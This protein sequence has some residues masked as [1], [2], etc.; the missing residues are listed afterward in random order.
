MLN[1]EHYVTLAGN[2]DKWDSEMREL[3]QPGTHCSLTELQESQSERG[4]IPAVLVESM[5][6][7]CVRYASGLQ[8]FGLLLSSRK[9]GRKISREEAIAWG[10]QWANQDPNNREFYA[11]KTDLEKVDLFA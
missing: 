5:L 6:G 7:W 9:L 2:P 3:R 8:G 10:V 4:Y 1:T 11:S